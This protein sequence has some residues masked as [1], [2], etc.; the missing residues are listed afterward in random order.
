MR[1]SIIAG[2]MSLAVIAASGGC[3]RRPLNEIPDGSGGANGGSFGGAAPTGGA[4][5]NPSGSGGAVG[6][7]GAGG[8]AGASGDA[9]AIGSAGASGSAGAGGS[10]GTGG[11]GGG[12]G[13]GAGSA[14]RTLTFLSTTYPV[15]GHVAVALGDLDG[16]GSLDIAIA[17]ERLATAGPMGNVLLNDERG[18]FTA[19]VRYSAP[20]RAI[21]LGDLDGD[22]R[23][24]IAGTGPV[25]LYNNGDATFRDPVPIVSHT[26]VADTVAIADLNGDGHPDL[27][28]A[29]P[30]DMNGRA[31]VL[32]VLVGNGRGDFMLTPGYPVGS[33]GGYS[34]ATGD[35]DGDGDTDLVVAADSGSVITV[36]FNRGDATFEP[37]AYMV[38]APH[39]VAL[40]DLD[41][42]ARPEI[43]VAGN[44]GIRVMHNDGDGTFTPP[45]GNYPVAPIG[46]AAADL[47]GD[48]HVDLVVAESATYL[49]RNLGDRLERPVPLPCGAAS[50]SIAIGDV[51]AD[52]K[53]DVVGGGLGLSV[54]VTINTGQ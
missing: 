47:D 19:T 16:N 11:R 36:L 10:A 20:L 7:A 40:A 44:G 1:A 38:S 4:G 21:A 14:P 18:R 31:G 52:G 41:G 42:D 32:S 48:G 13:G 26:A 25:V 15:N 43:A 39:G 28:A 37:V 29:G 9:G 33:G 46:V 12:T 2:A 22:G 35:V 54:C 24:D 30:L 34:I 5:T 17:T 8:S 53:P 51:N 45:V 3:G 50:W 49:L 27:V 23:V 6:V